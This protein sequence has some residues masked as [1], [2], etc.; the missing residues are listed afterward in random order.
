M[1]RFS[2][3]QSIIIGSA[4]TLHGAVIK[5][6]RWSVAIVETSEFDSPHRLLPKILQP[7]RTSVGPKKRRR[8]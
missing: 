1:A 2:A 4:T 3:V 7:I 5:T 8:L 6:S